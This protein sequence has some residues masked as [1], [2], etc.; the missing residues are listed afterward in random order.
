MLW[1]V[2][3]LECRGSGLRACGFEGFEVSGLILRQ[4]RA[5]QPRKGEDKAPW[6]ASECLGFL[7]SAAVVRVRGLGLRFLFRVFRFGVIGFTMCDLCFRTCLRSYEASSVLRCMSW[8]GCFPKA[9]CS[10]IVYT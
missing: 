7:L 8:E 9:P 1:I 2:E 3:F 6:H 5:G 4:D 10:H